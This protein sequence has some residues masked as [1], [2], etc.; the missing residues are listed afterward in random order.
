VLRVVQDRDVEPVEARLL[1]DHGR[2]LS[3]RHV[4][5]KSRSR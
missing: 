5:G 4:R 3:P 2:D 1:A